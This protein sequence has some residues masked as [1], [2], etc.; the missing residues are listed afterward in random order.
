[1]GSEMCIRDRESGASFGIETLLGDALQSE[2]VVARE[3]TRVTSLSR[4]VFLLILRDSFLVY[5]VVLE[6]LATSLQELINGRDGVKDAAKQ[7]GGGDSSS[8]STVHQRL[9]LNSTTLF[10]TMPPEDLEH[11]VAKSRIQ[12]L[13]TGTVVV[14][15]NVASDALYYVVS[16]SLTI[17]SGEQ[18][19]ARLSVGDNFGKLGFLGHQVSLTGV[20]AV[21]SDAV[22]L[23]VDGEVI[24][25]MT[26]MNAH[27]IWATLCH[28]SELK[29]RYARRL[30][31]FTWF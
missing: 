25:S 11:I 4:D 27:T 30:E 31:E 20:I 10:G 17:R 15:E 6:S 23:S 5:Q 16:G 24:D 28:I 3:R 19:H 18:I 1:M 14:D 2:R 9:M 21:E 7:N 13:P 22:L 26:W 12:T 8:T 29:N